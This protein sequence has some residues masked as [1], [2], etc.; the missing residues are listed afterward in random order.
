MGNPNQ[1]IIVV[2]TKTLF[3]NNYFEGF[4]PAEEFDYESKILSNYQIMRRG[5]VAEPKNHPE[6]NAERNTEF[7]QPI[8]YT[9]IV[10]PQ[11]KKVFAYQ[12]SSKDSEYKEKRLQGKWS[13]GLGGHIEPFDAENG[14]FNITHC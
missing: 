9:M 6:G 14:N 7:K 13:W 2:N 8:G 12:R 5:S 3:G 10:N 4:R 1:R 11:F